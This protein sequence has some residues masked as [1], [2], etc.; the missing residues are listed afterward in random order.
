MGDESSR[1]ES[2]GS[3]LEEV[4][5]DADSTGLAAFVRR[6][7]VIISVF[8]FCTLAGIAIGLEVLPEEWALARRII[9]GAVG[10]AGVGLI[11]TAPRIVG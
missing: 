3:D 4:Q 9:G 11:C 7:P 10:G 1:D 5:H 6:Y 2:V 8:V